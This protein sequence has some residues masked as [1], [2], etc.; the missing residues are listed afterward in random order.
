MVRNMIS[1]G[2]TGQVHAVGPHGGV[3]LGRPIRKSVKDI[4]FVMDM[5][6]I[7]TPAPTVPALGLA[8]K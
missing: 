4:R 2:F 5:A 7:L 3:I 8:Q 6:V 1:S